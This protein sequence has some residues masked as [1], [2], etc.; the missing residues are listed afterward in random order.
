[1]SILRNQQKTARKKERNNNHKFHM[2]VWEA[3]QTHYCSNGA[4]QTIRKELKRSQRFYLTLI[5]S[6]FHCCYLISFKCLDWL[7]ERSFKSSHAFKQTFKQLINILLY[8]LLN[9]LCGGRLQAPSLHLF[10]VYTTLDCYGND[11]LSLLLLLLIKY[12]NND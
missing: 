10:L 11:P 6:M 5:L 4:A 9:E 7:L 2:I 3:V 1:M 12:S 8:F